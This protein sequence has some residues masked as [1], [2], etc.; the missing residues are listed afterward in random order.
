M[1][2]V[3]SSLLTG[4]AGAEAAEAKGAGPMVRVEVTVEHLAAEAKVAEVKVVVSVG[5]MAAGLAT[6]LTRRWLRP[7]SMSAAGTV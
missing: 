5:V 2:V 1:A 7:G 6:E 3:A 4:L